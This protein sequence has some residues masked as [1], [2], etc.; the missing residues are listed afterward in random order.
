MIKLGK[1]NNRDVEYIK[2]TDFSILKGK[3]PNDNWILLAIADI[4]QTN[5]IYE[6]SVICFDHNVRYVCGT[7]SG[8][9]K[10]D[11]LFDDQYL[12]RLFKTGKELI[13][14]NM[15]DMPMTVWS[16]N[17]EEEFWFAT[18]LANEDNVELN[19]VVC[20]NLTDVDYENKISE[21]IVKLKTGW[22]PD[23]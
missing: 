7:G 10:I 6:L 22:T 9:T 1:I 23:I 14:E 21:L 3:L 12:I 13:P 17:F 15:D 8:G 16:E 5:E 4:E 20:I 11:D 2:T 18:Y 19:K